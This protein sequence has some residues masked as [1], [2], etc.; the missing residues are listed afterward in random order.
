MT[1]TTHITDADIEAAI[2]Q[3][4]DHDH[5]DALTVDDVRELLALVQEDATESWSE[6]LD[7]IERGET[8]VVADTGDIVVLETGE[9]NLYDEALN[10]LADHTSVEYD[11]VAASVVSAAI[12]NAANRLSDYAWGV[13]YPYLIAKPDT[14][15]AGEAYVEA[16]VNGLQARGLSP[17]QAWAYYGVELQGYSRSQWG[18]RKGDYDHKTVSDALKNAK[19]NLP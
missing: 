7:N 3:H 12:H 14:H 4:D 1:D 16:V 18:S 6:F 5:P 15:A 9:H 17:G 11:D 13:S 10:R 8:T 2:S 19:A